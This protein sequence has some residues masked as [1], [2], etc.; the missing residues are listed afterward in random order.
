LLL[1]NRRARA[2]F[3][4]I[5]KTFFALGAC[6]DRREIQGGIAGARRNEHDE[7]NPM[8]PRRSIAKKRYSPYVARSF[9]KSEADST[10]SSEYPHCGAFRVSFEGG[11][12]REVTSLA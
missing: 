5:P 10:P 4:E 2:H 7:Q 3:R 12:V 8:K 1:E 6:K 11:K 9:C